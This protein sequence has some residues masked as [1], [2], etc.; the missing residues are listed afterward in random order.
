MEERRT[1]DT[2]I[3]SRWNAPIHNCLKAIDAHTELYFLHRDPWHL[4]KAAMLRSYLHELK[5]YI[6]L[7]EEK[8]RR[9]EPL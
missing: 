8:A 6:H 5:T 4:E 2:P 1:F 3:R 7:Q 9:N